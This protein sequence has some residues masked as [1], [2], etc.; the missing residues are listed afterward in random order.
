MVF[1]IIM[2]LL[3]HLGDTLLAILLQFFT[4]TNHGNPTVDLF[5][6]TI[7]DF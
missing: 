4:R 3:A 6:D 7:H 1:E 2:H 5:V